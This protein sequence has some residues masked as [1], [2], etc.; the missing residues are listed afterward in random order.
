MTRKC[1]YCKEEFI[2]TRKDRK[3]CSNNCKT[4][5][6]IVRGYGSNIG[7]MQRRRRK[8]LMPFFDKRRI[9]EICGFIAVHK[10]QLDIDHIDGNNQNNEP[11]NFQV[12]CANCHRLKTQINK[13][14]ENK[15]D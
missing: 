4:Y 12:L 9:C 3:Y 14:W 13:D 5:A 6:K 8:L 10:C 7:S 11:S 15:V 1:S 2:L